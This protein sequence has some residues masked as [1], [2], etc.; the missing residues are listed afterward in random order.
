MKVIGVGASFARL[1]VRART[2]LLAAAVV[3]AALVSGAVLL[4]ETLDDALVL[5]RDRAVVARARD[6]AVLAQ[7]DA[8]P[9]ELSVTPDEDFVQVVNVDGVVVAGT[10]GRPS[11][12]PAASFTPTGAG[13][14]VRRVDHIPDGSEFENYRI[15]ALRVE[16]PGGPVTV[17]AGYAVESITESQ[18]A[19]RTALRQGI[20]ALVLL[21]LVGTWLL[22]GRA[23]RPVAAIRK[24]VDDISL[25]ALDGRVPEPSS[26]DEVRAL[27]VTMNAMLDR[28]EAASNRQ[29]D[30]VADASHELQNPIAALRAQLEVSLAHPPDATEWPQTARWLL[31][32]TERMERLVR[33]LLYLARADSAQITVDGGKELDLDDIVLEEAS[34][35]KARL[36]TVVL[37][38][39]RVSAAPFR[40]SPDALTRLVRN[41]LENAVRYAASRVEVTLTETTDQC[42]RLEVFDDGRGIAPADRERIFERF[43]RLE[44]DRGRGDG[45]T[46]L[47]L[48]ICREIVRS[49]GGSIRFA[50][51]RQ[52][53]RVVVEWPPAAADDHAE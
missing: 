20:P 43:I 30:F 17:Y 5:E 53:A 33:D 29:R 36:S 11:S 37:D 19:V 16:A 8:L 39:S 15:A 52:G 32:D 49:Q 35:L 44:P 23:L 6:V 18:R 51:V 2:T 13:P 24:K 46:G 45:G 48:S 12:P 4:S 28:L 38:T 22:V 47:G 40:G 34:R 21:L 1:S 14:V 3:L 27:A 50:D 7:Q 41:L 31:E 26:R 42:I 25:H 10:T 9:R